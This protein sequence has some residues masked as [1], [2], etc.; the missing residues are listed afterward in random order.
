M[1]LP[2]G[3]AHMLFG[4]SWSEPSSPA[5]YSVRR[6]ASRTFATTRRSNAVTSDVL[7]TS[8]T[9]REASAEDPTSGV[10]GLRQTS[11]V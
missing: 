3:T 7:P 10:Y 4:F 1:I 6:D 8:T 2:L 5:K 11:G 9:D